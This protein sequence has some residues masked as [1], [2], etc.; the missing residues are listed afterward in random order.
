MT[1]IS[2][3]Q[4]YTE[5][6]NWSASHDWDIF[7]TLNFA[8]KHKL[9]RDEAQS[10]FRRYWNCVDRAVYGQRTQSRVERIV[11][12]QFG[13]LGD[14]PHLHF[15]AK[16]PIE[17]DCLCAHLNA[18]WADLDIS[19]A[20]VADNVILPVISVQ[21]STQYVFHEF[22]RIGVDTLNVEL[23]HKNQ[24]R[25]DGSDPTPPHDCAEVRLASKSRPI[26]QLGAHV[27]FMQHMLDAQD[28]YQKRHNK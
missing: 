3:K 27:A 4:L 22:H 10:L 12:S 9:K 18:I 20:P 11:C 13:V 5:L 16:A 1:T 24:L 19:T 25:W 21:R 26:Q 7:G 14:N 8:P 6:V 17:P 15:V 2:R 28:R 23:C